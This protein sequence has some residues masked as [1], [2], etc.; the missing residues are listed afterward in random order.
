MLSEFEENFSVKYPIP[1]KDT[2]FQHIIDFSEIGICLIDG[3]L[4]YS[5]KVPI[6]E[7][8]HFRI[9]HLLPIPQRRGLNFL[10]PVPRDEYILVNDKKL[11]MYLPTKSF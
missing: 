11:S 8:D 4:L 3:K 1:L 9:L 5:I 10:A 2:N 6:L 7:N